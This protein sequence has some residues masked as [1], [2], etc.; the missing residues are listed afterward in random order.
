MSEHLPTVFPGYPTHFAGGDDEGASAVPAHTD[1]PLARSVEVTD[2]GTWFDRRLGFDPRAGVTTADW[3]AA[4]TQRPAETT[5]GWGVPRRAGAVG[6]GARRTGPGRADR[7]GRPPVPLPPVPGA[8]RGPVHP[9][10]AR[11]VPP[12]PE[13]RTSKTPEFYTRA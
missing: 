6:G 13:S 5:G 3:P 2:L 11:V 4:P 12:A 9:R 10:A 8:A 7:P 1:G